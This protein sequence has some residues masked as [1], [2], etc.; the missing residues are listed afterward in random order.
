LVGTP[1]KLLKIAV[2]GILGLLLATI[3]LAALSAA[4]VF[5]SNTFLDIKLETGIVFKVLGCFIGLSFLTIQI[6]K[7]ILTNEN[8]VTM[9]GVSLPNKLYDPDFKD[10]FEVVDKK[11]AKENIK[12]KDR[13]AELEVLLSELNDENE[14]NLRTMELL[15]YVNDIFVRHH[16][17]ASRLVRSMLLLWMEGNDDWLKEF[18]NNVLD[19]CTTTL[20]K[21]RSD[22]SSAIFINQ[23]DALTIFAYNRIDYSSAR[24]RRFEKGQGFAGNVWANSEPIIINN[25]SES[26]YFKD[27]FEPKH[28]YGSILGYPIR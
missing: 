7:N 6:G 27:E 22:K 13:N 4:I 5:L 9:A 2:A 21:D 12:L 28:D 1:M 3:L 18:C 16:N 11:I 23:D 20:I 25:I 24:E 14:Q 17:N 10:Y 8:P 26:E 15:D 19:E